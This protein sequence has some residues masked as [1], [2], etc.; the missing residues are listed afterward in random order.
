[1]FQAFPETGGASPAPDLSR[2]SKAGLIWLLRHLPA[3]WD[4]NFMDCQ[5]CA[6]GL[7]ANQWGV[8]LRNAYAYASASRA[9]GISELDGLRIFGEN[10]QSPNRRLPEHVAKDLEELCEFEGASA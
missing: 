5:K 8:D 7:V 10:P 4:W 1:M 2:P 9:I 6:M 3:G